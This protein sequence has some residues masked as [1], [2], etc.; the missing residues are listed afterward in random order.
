MFGLLLEQMPGFDKARLLNCPAD[1][2]KRL[3]WC[4]KEAA[5]ILFSECLQRCAEHAKVEFVRKFFGGGGSGGSSAASA[6]KKESVAASSSVAP[7]RQMVTRSMA[8]VAPP[9]MKQMSMSSFLLDKSLVSDIKKVER[10]NKKIEEKA[11]VVAEE[12]VAD[13]VADVVEPVA[14]KGRKKAV[15]K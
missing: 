2:E 5:N 4:E 13:V 8:T 15:K 9:A 14:V 11:A 12:V 10:K 3:D 7:Q 1:S 6:V